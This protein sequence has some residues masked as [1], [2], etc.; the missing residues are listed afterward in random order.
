MCNATNHKSYGLGLI[1]VTEVFKHI[2]HI[3]DNIIM[4][5]HQIFYNKL[6]I[7]DI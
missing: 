7:V 5:F 6:M 1:P 2:V 3:I 4:F